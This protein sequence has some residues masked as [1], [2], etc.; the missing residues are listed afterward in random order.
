MGNEAVI[1]KLDIV[2]SQVL[3]PPIDPPCQSIRH[4]DSFNYIGYIKTHWLVCKIAVYKILLSRNIG[5]LL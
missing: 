2:A 3:N 5:N 1:A 4:Q